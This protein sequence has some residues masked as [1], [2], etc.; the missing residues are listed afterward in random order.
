MADLIR[1][2]TAAA[3]GEWGPSLSHLRAAAAGFEHVGM[4]LY[5]TAARRR[6]GEV[7][8]GDEGKEAIEA[9]DAWMLAQ[10]I[11]NPAQMSQM[12]APG[13]FSA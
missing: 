7:I 10:Q 3:R 2:G 8:G 1:A 11:R 6:I 12:L 5:A 9:S 4:G 13:R